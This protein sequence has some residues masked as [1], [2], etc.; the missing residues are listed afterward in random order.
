MQTTKNLSCWANPFTIDFLAG[1]I[2]LNLALI[3]DPFPKKLLVA[4]P[5]YLKLSKSDTT[6][7][8]HG[9]SLV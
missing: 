1:N 4:R 5:Y 9:M 8:S 6:E 3:D 7:Q 2:E